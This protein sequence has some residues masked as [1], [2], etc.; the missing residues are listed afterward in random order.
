MAFIKVNKNMSHEQ[1]NACKEVASQFKHKQAPS[2]FSKEFTSFCR[3]MLEKGSCTRLETCTFAHS[4]EQLVPLLCA[5]DQKCR[6][7]HC[8]RFHPNRGQTKEEY[9]SLNNMVFE[10]EN[11]DDKDDEKIEE[12]FFYMDGMTEYQMHQ[13]HQDILDEI[14][15]H[16]FMDEMEKENDKEDDFYR[17]MEEFE[18]ELEM[19]F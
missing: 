7:D 11:E 1:L 2:S 6:N 13:M 8:T 3:H 16:S 5:W 12:M 17:H 4:V 14:D 18:N 10:K 9:M 19:L 15:F